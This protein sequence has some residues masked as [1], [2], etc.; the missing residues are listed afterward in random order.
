[1]KCEEKQSNGYG[2]NIKSKQNQT[3]SVYICW[4]WT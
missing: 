1:M 4:I 2:M 3:V